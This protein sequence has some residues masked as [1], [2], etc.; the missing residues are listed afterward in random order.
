M[1]ERRIG[2]HIVEESKFHLTSGLLGRGREM[3][4]GKSDETLLIAMAL[5]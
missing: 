5:H 3:Y 4:G 1:T 2:A